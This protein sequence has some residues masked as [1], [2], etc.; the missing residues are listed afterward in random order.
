[1]FAFFWCVKEG[2][3]NH[4]SEYKPAFAATHH[5]LRLDFT[6]TVI[7]MNTLTL[8]AEQCFGGPS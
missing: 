4:W 2:K 7:N 6:H 3:K 8:T 5:W 1:M